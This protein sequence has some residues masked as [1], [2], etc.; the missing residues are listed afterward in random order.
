MVGTNQYQIPPAVQRLRSFA[1]N[2]PL[3]CAF[4]SINTSAP[5]PAAK[6]SKLVLNVKTEVNARERRW[7]E[8]ACFFDERASRN[9]SAPP[10]LDPLAL[11]RYTNP[12]LR[13][14]F[15]KEYR[16]LVL[17]DLTGKQVLDVG[18]GDG[19][20]SVL[21]AKMGAM[22]TG[23]DISP[24]SIEFAER[25]AEANGVSDRT[26]FLCSPLESADLP[27]KHF[28][29]I[30]GDAVLHHLIAELDFVM[31]QLCRYTRP[32]GTLLFAEPVNFSPILR[33]LR[34]T[35][36]VHTDATPDERPLEPAEIEIVRHHIPGLRIR[37]F[38][39]FGR[40]DRLLLKDYNFE[41]S[42]P[43]RRC[44]SD[45]MARAD[46]VCLRLPLLEN[47]CGTAV[48]HGKAPGQPG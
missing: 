21:L 8:E 37:R 4:A 40:L 38:S 34:F 2:T 5:A 39:F 41:R 22:V 42:H 36:P 30:W 47:F 27:A 26:R 48:L 17:G 9:P 13:S 24:A 11:R 23:I 31:A 35:I 46:A 43:L 6:Y 14:R 33:R 7:R 25:R 15:N 44:I 12:K 19:A 32:G 16:F 1:E 10:L 28:D 3:A 18:C 29:V 20:N 45:L